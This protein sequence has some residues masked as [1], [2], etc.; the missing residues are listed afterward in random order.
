MATS[1][2]VLHTGGCQCGAVRYALMAEPTRN[3]VCH[4]RMCQ[5]AVGGPFA[6]FAGIKPGDFEWTRGTPAVY[7]SST[8]AIRH[9][10]AA[11]G[12]PLTFRYVER[13]WMNV[14]MGSLDDA[15]AAAP[16]LQFGM[17]LRVPW[18]PH[19]G[20]LPGTTTEQ[21][22]PAEAMARLA[23]LQHPDR[24]TGLGWSPPKAG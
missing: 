4:C 20:M 7:A 15:N 19:V 18:L 12:T 23:S 22:V 13:D 21:M 1:R 17:E 6:A 2:K 5:K 8:L 9:F 10:C 16:A 11:C 24:E 3:H 14:T